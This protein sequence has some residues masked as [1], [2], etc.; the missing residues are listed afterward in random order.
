MSI[1][2]HFTDSLSVLKTYK[3]SWQKL[4]HIQYNNLG[5]VN[6]WEYFESLLQTHS[7]KN[8]KVALF[9]NKAQND[10]LIGIFPFRNFKLSRL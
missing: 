9:T 5:L 8:F 3:S 4:C 2:I 6:H 1:N 10:E 7:K